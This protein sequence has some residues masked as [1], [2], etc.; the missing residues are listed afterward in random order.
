MSKE[1]SPRREIPVLDVGADWPLEILD[2]AFDRAIRLL[3]QGSGHVP[4]GALALAD[5]ISRRW[6]ERGGAAQLKEIDTIAARLGRPGAYFFNV[7]YEWGCTSSAG[8]S[9]DGRS[10]QLRRV[11]DWPNKG[12][13]R[14][15]VAAHVTG[16]S[17]GDWL[18]LTWPGYTGVLQAMAPGRFA[19]SLNQAPME[20]LVG[21]Y[22]LDW[23][24]NRVKVWSRPRL[25]AA[26][27]LRQVFEGARDFAEA[28]QRLTETP[29]ALPSI[30]ILAGLAPDESCVIERLPERAHVIDIA[31]GPAC[32][33]NTWQAPGW[34]GR[35]RG[36][37]NARRLS[38]IRSAA[39]SLD[40]AFGW[41]RP[42]ILNARTRLVFVAEPR[43]GAFAAQGF[44]S[45]GPATAVLERIIAPRPHRPP[46]RPELVAP[47]P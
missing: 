32:A 41:L 7:S 23:L 1:A 15:V 18:S 17:V 35:A 37:N 2:R 38:L 46:H 44:E 30:Y 19:A 42:P 34:S 12:L 25:T 39:H 8:P 27:L 24:A 10:A 36:R 14:G 20:R 4:A 9:P 47:A 40:P 33:A 28:K 43:T 6:L 3:D 21:A 29:I 31:D 13:G 26:H 11:L 45:D 22:P 16:C 5:T